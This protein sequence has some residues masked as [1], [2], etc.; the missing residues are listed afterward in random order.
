MLIYFKQHQFLIHRIMLI[1][2]NQYGAIQR[3]SY[4]CLKKPGGMKLSL[5]LLTRRVQY[6]QRQTIS[7][8]F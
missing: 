1:M 8:D 7:F 5:F 6:I 4:E 2:I 3:S